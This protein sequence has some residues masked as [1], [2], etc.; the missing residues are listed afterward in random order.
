MVE[1]S[2]SS[3]GIRSIAPPRGSLSST[4]VVI[5]FTAYVLLNLRC[6]LL[7]ADS[8]VLCIMGVAATSLLM[9]LFLRP[10]WVVPLYI[11]IAG[12]SI[13]IPLGATGILS[14]LFAGNLV[15]A[16]LVVVGVVGTIRI[17]GKP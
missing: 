6:V 10:R 5:V 11:L 16:L 13:T 1:E 17:Q 3:E 15:F 7:M 12:P 8:L 9:F 4:K 14:R 2:F